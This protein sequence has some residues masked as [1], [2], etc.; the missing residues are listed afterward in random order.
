MQRNDGRLQRLRQNEEK[1]QKDF[2]NQMAASVKNG[3]PSVWEIF[4]K[5]KDT[6]K[7]LEE[8]VCCG[9]GAFAVSCGMYC[10]IWQERR[11]CYR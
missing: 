11:T 5:L 2:I 10:D 3:D 6:Q 8:M 1:I 4:N 7:E 9:I